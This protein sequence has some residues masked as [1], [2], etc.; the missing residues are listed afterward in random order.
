MLAY[1]DTLD[2]AES[3]YCQKDTDKIYIQATWRTKSENYKEKCDADGIKPLSYFTF[4][5]VF[6]QLKL[7]VHTPRKDQ[8]DDCVGYKSGQISK[9]HYELHIKKPKRAKREKKYD[10]RSA[11]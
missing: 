5:S 1:F 2:K 9:K 7:S 3:H 6:E 8:C 11:I 4:A 10:K